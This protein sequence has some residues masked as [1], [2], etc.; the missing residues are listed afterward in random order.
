MVCGLS[1][2][3]AIAEM[4]GETDQQAPAP[5]GPGDFSHLDQAM[6]MDLVVIEG[7]EQLKT[8]L[9]QDLEEW[10]IFLHPYQRKLV[11]IIVKDDEEVKGNG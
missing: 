3:E 10:R 6:N 2:N 1:L 9:A 7:E 8:I 11:D 4:L 5:A